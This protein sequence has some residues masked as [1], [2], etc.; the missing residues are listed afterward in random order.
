MIQ[1]WK[2]LKFWERNISCLEDSW[3]KPEGLSDR[4]SIA[5]SFCLTR[6]LLT[7]SRC[8]NMKSI[9]QDTLWHNN[10]EWRMWNL[11]LMWNLYL[12]DSTFKIPHYTL[13][14]VTRRLVRRGGR[15]WYFNRAQ[16]SCQTIVPRLSTCGH[17]CLV[18][19]P[20]SLV[21]LR[22]GLRN[23]QILSACTMKCKNTFCLEDFK[24][25]LFK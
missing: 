2:D 10:V 13:K 25:H 24:R 12:S 5:V 3:F 19:H 4:R 18:R 11:E 23:A 17:W 21:R 15:V 14:H 16:L 20:L 22:I 8:M 6:Q 7:V 1:A 9:W